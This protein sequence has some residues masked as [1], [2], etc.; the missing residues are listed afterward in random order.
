MILDEKD[1]SD[2]RDEK[3][4]IRAALQAEEDRMINEQKAMN[5]W[6]AKQ[7]AKAAAEAN[8]PPEQKGSKF[9]NLKDPDAAQKPKN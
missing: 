3:E 2:N 5:E 6:K 4:R 8:K 1:L 7:A 9:A